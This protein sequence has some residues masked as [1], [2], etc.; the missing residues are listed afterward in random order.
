MKRD[1]SFGSS[2]LVLATLILC[3]ALTSHAQNRE[4][5]VISAKAGGVNSVSGNVMV[6]SQGAAE[7]RLLN[8]Q[9]NLDKGDVVKTGTEG[10]VEVLLNPGSY[11]RVAENSEFQFA[12]TSLENLAVR[13][14]R[15]SAIVEAT[16]DDHVELLATLYTPQTKV[17][18]VRRGVYRINVLPGSTTELIVHKG[19]AFVGDDS[20]KAVKD[21]KKVVVGNGSV[22]VAKSGSDKD[23]LDVWSKQRAET[24]AKANRRISGVALT[25]AFAS[26]LDSG[27]YRNW[28]F[29]TSFLSPHYGLWFYDPFWGYTFIPPYGSCWSPYGFS[30]TGWP[31]GYAWGGAFAG[32][33]PVRRIP[34]GNGT[35]G[36]GGG[37]VRVNQRSV[38][39]PV[40]S[41]ITSSAVRSA[42]TVSRERPS[43]SNG[44]AGGRSGGDMSGR[45]RDTVGRGERRM[46]ESTHQRSTMSSPSISRPAA[47]GGVGRRRDQ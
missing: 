7:E 36:T 38:P 30:Y 34:P 4:K 32:G 20:S 10:R 37:P 25:N 22:E 24:L 3:A 43:F 39:R 19:R 26:V 31:I 1:L 9:D 13:L 29:N 46:P 6:Q 40:P 8:A 5:Y 14:T 42:G 17:S 33:I 41:D 15:G 35:I 21:G 45:S 27:W 2:L 11:L 28:F 47:G 44:P 18:I 12:D 16:G 23:S